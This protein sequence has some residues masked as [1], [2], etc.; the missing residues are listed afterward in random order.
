LTC[1]PGCDSLSPFGGCTS[2]ATG[3]NTCP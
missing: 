1:K 3:C 2:L